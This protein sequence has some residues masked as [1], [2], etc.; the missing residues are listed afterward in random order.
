MCDQKNEKGPIILRHVGP[1][2]SKDLFHWRN[3]PDVR[4]NFFNSEPLAWDEHEKWFHTQLKDPKTVAYMAYKKENK[5]GTIRFEDHGSSIKVSVMVNPAWIGK[6]FGTD[7]IER[8]VALYRSEKK[9]MK[10]IVAEIKIENKASVK[11]FQKAGFKESFVTY[12][13]DKNIT[14]TE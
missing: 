8:G 1:G 12:V 4:K 11:A 6:G 3:N 2:D 10:P 13:F 9:N 7:L 14:D 5:I